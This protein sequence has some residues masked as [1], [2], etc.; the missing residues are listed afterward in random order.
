VVE[1]EAAPSE[2]GSLDFASQALLATS[3]RRFSEALNIT[4]LADA[5]VLSVRELTGLRPGDGVPLR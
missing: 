4:A 5:V 1:L 3:V 2:G